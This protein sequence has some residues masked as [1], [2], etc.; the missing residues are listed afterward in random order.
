MAR[1]V[2]TKIIAIDDLT[3]E[4]VDEKN[5]ET[6]RYSWG[7]RKYEIDLTPENAKEFRDMMSKYVS[8]SRR[9]DNQS[10]RNQPRQRR[11]QMM[12]I[13]QWARE[14]GHVVSESGKLP[15]RIIRA[16]EEAQKS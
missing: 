14:N 9:S 15:D 3:K 4:E 8:V 16:Y 13:R 7:G 2:I 6:I 10:F 12:T 1:R 5:I 11:D